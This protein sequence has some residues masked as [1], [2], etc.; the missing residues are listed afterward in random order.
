[1]QRAVLLAA[2][3]AA[4]AAPGTAAARG[5]HTSRTITPLRI[6]RPAPANATVAGFKLDL[7]SARGAGAALART[8]AALPRGITIYAVLAR[9]RRSDRVSGVV[10]AVNRASVVA[11]SAA[12]RT[13]HRTITV[14]LRHAAIPKGFRIVVHLS[15][16]GDVVGRHR[17]FV[18]S[19]Y[20]RGSDLGSAVKL[21]GPAL[22]GITIGT[23]VQSA[24][25]SARGSLP[26]PAEGEF[27]S[28][29]N[30]RSGSLTFARDPQAA[31]Q[32]DGTASFNY[33]LSAFGVLADAGHRFS[34]CTFPG[35]SCAISTKKHPNDYVRFTLSAP[36][37]PRGAALP[38]TLTVGPASTLPLPFQLFGFNMAGSRFGPLLTS[39][40][41]Q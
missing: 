19:R 23:L 31:N 5:H 1:M 17:R 16:S 8:A 20:F 26:Y 4:I 24:C 40:P 13:R 41:P 32:L 3:V 25:N 39:G 6:Q 34:A 38:L 12:R 9:Q 18:C 10:V 22:P 35:G 28:A 15:Q 30:A 33:A 27:L 11:A 2:A 37:P 7:V 21:A 36:P 29:L 14:N